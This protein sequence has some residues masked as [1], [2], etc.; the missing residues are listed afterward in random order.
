MILALFECLKTWWIN[1]I[2]LSKWLHLVHDRLLSRFQSKT[3]ISCFWCPYSRR[4]KYAQAEKHEKWKCSEWGQ[5]DPIMFYNCPTTQKYWKIA[6]KVPNRV[7]FRRMI[8]WRTKLKH[9]FRCQIDFWSR[10]QCD[11][12]ILRDFS[13]QI[14]LFAR[15]LRDLQISVISAH[16]FDQKM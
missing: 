10:N 14:K 12:Q 13:V 8:L 4:S 3:L 7:V 11:F 1:K 15:H 6:P 5:I 2:S 16:E 9:P